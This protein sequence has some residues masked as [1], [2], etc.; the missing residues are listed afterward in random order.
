MLNSLLESA[1][2][3]NFDLFIYLKDA[4]AGLQLGD[5]GASGS[6]GK[7]YAFMSIDRS[8]YAPLFDYL[9]SKEIRVKNP[10]EVGPA[11]AFGKAGVEEGDLDG[12]DGEG[13][14]SEDDGDY[15]GG[16]NSSH[17]GDS[18]DSGSDNEA[19]SAQGDD[20]PAKKAKVT[21]APKESSSSSAS[22]VSIELLAIREFALILTYKNCSE[23]TKVSW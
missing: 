1:A 2:T 3:R 11:A 10:V 6:G 4:A 9:N 8:E 18:D 13:S 15:D 23:K 16:G 12:S 5:G 14:G 7:E 17:S 19:G 21:K 22:T 20:K